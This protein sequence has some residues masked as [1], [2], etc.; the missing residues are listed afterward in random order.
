MNLPLAEIITIGDEIL[1][2]Q[3]TD[4][5]FQ[6]ISQQ[7]GLA[8]FKVVRKTSVGDIREEILSAFAEAEKRADAIIITGGLGPT[9]DDLTRP[10]MAEYFGTSLSMHAATLEHI[11]QL[12]DKRGFNFTERN[13][14]Q[15]ML[16]ESCTPITNNWGTAAGM[17]FER[18]GKIFIS[19]PGVPHEMKNMMEHSILPLLKQYFKTQ[20]L[21]HRTIKTSGI[22]ES[23][24]AD[25]VKE[26][27]EALPQHIKLAYLP[28]LGMV[29]L[30]LTATGTRLETLEQEAEEQIKKVLPRIGRYVYGY[31][32]DTL[33]FAIGNKLKEKKLTIATAESCSTGFIAYSLASVPGSSAYYQGSIIAYQ[34]RLKTKLLQ[35][36]EETLQTYGAVSEETV[37][38]M[39]SGVREQ[40]NTDIGISASG[41]AGPTGGTPDKPVGLIWIAVAGPASTRTKKLQLTQDRD[42]NIR[43]TAAYLLTL[44][45]QTLNEI[46]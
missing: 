1:Y 14:L 9:A 22:G 15:A 30:R 42:L 11:R 7:L 29:D 16:P 32:T 2:G 36:A 40:L 31:D 39:A 38:E 34:N 46:D 26:W 6:W 8:G 10:V 23:W 20:V 28:H 33:P 4:T 19:M 12:F 3:I 24:L 21:H 27:E 35:V 25:E 44:L 13:Q 17:W 5:N 45:W 37:R 41:I 18:E 43:Y